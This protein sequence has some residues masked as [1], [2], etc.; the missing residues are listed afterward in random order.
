MLLPSESP[1]HLLPADLT[2]KNLTAVDA[3]LAFS[4]RQPSQELKCQ[5]WRWGKKKKQERRN[6]RRK[7]N[8]ST[9]KG[10]KTSHNYLYINA[11]MMGNKQTE[12]Q[13]IIQGGG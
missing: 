9:K 12:L 6:E 13:V 7:Q 5:A 4:K 1:S 2:H 10:N 11:R 3:R 8:Y